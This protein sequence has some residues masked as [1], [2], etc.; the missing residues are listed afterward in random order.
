LTNK[1]PKYIVPNLTHISI[2][3]TNVFSVFDKLVPQQY[4]V[5]IKPVEAFDIDP[6]YAV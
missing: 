2:F 5:S 1:K 3:E 6:Q 4:L